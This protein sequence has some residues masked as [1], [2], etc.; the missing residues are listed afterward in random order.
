MKRS[1]GVEESATKYFL[2]D[3]AD[4]LH[5]SLRVFHTERVTYTAASGLRA[6]LDPKLFLTWQLRP[7]QSTCDTR[8]L[9]GR[10]PR[11]RPCLEPDDIDR[12]N[13]VA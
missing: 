3:E 13:A 7:T 12:I 4:G 9:G 10:A 2:M 8:A 6:S 5:Y 11:K 1:P